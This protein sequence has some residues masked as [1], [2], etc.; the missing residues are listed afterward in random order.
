MKSVCDYENN[1]SYEDELD[2]D[3]NETEKHLNDEDDENDDIIFFFDP[4]YGY[5][6]D[7]EDCNEDNDLYNEN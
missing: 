1:D 7:E 2:D 6:E 3:E 4:E 5:T